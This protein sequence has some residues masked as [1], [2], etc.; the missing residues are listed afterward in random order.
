MADEKK[1]GSDESPPEVS[2]LDKKKALRWFEQGKQVVETRN[3]DY[4][5]ECF[6]TG[7]GFWPDAVEEGHK[8]L[9]AIAVAR[10]H[11]GGK[12]P[13]LKET[14]K[15]SMTGKDAKQA[16]LNA[17]HLLCK[18]PRKIE[19]AEGLLKK[20]DTAGFKQT[21]KWIS[22]ILFDLIMNE[23]KPNIAKLKSMREILD[24]VG[25][26][27]SDQGDSVE[28]VHFLE[29]AVKAQDM[30]VRLDKDDGT[31]KNDLRDIASKLT[32]VRGRYR[33]DGDFRDSL[34]DADKAKLLHD[35][36][37]AV[38]ADDAVENLIAAARKDV[39]DNPGV[40]A[41]ISVLVE[42]L[43][44]REA[45]S[46][47]DEAISILEA[48]YKSS[49]NYSFKKSADDIRLKQISRQ[50]RDLK[51]RAQDSRS[52]EDKQQWRLAVMDQ[53]E[54]EIAIQQERCEQYPTDLR[55][56]FK[57]ASAMFKARRWDDAIPLFQES[58][59][60]P[61]YRIKSKMLMGRCFYEREIFEQAVEVLQEACDEYEVAGDDLSKELM[62][63]VGRALEAGGQSEQAVSAYGRLLRQEYNYMKGDVR[64]RLDELKKQA[65]G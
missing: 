2:D 22:P 36:D 55:Q 43:L 41:K 15:K 33:E 65:K 50:V 45:R 1:P 52:D 32:I 48:E 53:L 3:Y 8:V 26:L 59:N 23:K 29:L 61:R 62:Y 10:Q 18:D 38:Q 21:L 24:R 39:A 6:L 37:R 4:G 9:R 60:E 7:L 64:K 58:Q 19:Y 34:A 13:G 40:P 49:S 42:H 5:I 54:T 31:A 17:E 11:A 56:K 20:A 28:A 35:A 27:T 44:R 46:E 57:L 47:E 12:K 25:V 16:M 51:V 63:W 30:V 14:F